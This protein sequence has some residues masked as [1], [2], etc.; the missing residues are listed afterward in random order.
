MKI[1]VGKKYET[2]SGLIVETTSKNIIDEFPITGHFPD[3]PGA[4]QN[5]WTA[6]GNFFRNK[7]P[8]KFDLIKER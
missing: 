2:R 8:H 3:L 1:K 7:M 5:S 6:E 4:G